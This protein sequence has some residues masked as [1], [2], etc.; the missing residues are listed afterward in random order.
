MKIITRVSIFGFLL[1]VLSALFFIPMDKK[2]DPLI[3]SS[4]LADEVALKNKVSDTFSSDEFYR[5]SVRYF[6]N[7][8]S[9]S[10]RILSSDATIIQRLLSQTRYD[11][12]INENSDAEY[13]MLI[14][15][16]DDLE[17]KIESFYLRIQ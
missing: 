15:I 17:Y 7:E 16:G 5:R 13:L 1:V 4:V 8:S 10:Y 6:K 2:A 14:I 3:V 11:L 12:I 9:Y